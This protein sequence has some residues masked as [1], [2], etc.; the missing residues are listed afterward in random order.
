M[1]ATTAGQQWEDWILGHTEEWYTVCGKGKYPITEEE[2]LS[3]YDA[4]IQANLEP[5]V[6]VLFT[7]HGYAVC[8]RMLHQLSKVIQQGTKA[9]ARMAEM[10]LGQCRHS[11]F[12]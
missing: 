5:L 10:L 8:D 12:S 1:L 11:L 4:L 2:F 6:L 9:Q 3:L 7:C